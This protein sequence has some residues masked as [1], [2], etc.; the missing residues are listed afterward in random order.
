MAKKSDKSLDFEASLQELNH[1]VEQMEHGN[2]SLEDSLKNF[3]RGIYLTRTCQKALKDA[4]QKVQIL[5]GQNGQEKLSS[6][7]PTDSDDT[8]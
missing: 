2:L 7:Q 8:D 3:E 4:E 5:M 1:I 6:F